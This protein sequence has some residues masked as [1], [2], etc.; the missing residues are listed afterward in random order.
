M[1]LLVAAPAKK[2]ESVRLYGLDVVDGHIL[3]SAAY[4]A[5]QPLDLARFD[6]AAGFRAN[7]LHSSLPLAS[8]ATPSAVNR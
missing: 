3:V 6:Q 2:D 4:Q 7:L 5:G 8:S 1:G